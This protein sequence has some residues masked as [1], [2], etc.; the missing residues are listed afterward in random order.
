MIGDD[1][2]RLSLG[3]RP[4]AAE[5]CLGGGQVAPFTKQY[6][7][8]LAILI[9]GAVEVPLDGAMEEEDLVDVPAAAKPT[10]MPPSRGRELW[11]EDIN[12]TLTKEFGDRCWLATSTRRRGQSIQGIPGV[13]WSEAASSMVAPSS[14]LASGL[15]ASARQ[16]SGWTSWFSSAGRTRRA[17]PSFIS[18]SS[19][20]T[21]NRAR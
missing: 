9:D 1:G 6:V 16:P 14:P 2:R 3:G 11:T 10:T 17:A 18:P 19:I 4:G 13:W 7:D 21:S 20:S 5:E 12:A 8:Y 15:A